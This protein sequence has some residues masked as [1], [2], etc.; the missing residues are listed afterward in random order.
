MH[1]SQLVHKFP[2]GFDLRNV[3][4][5]QQIFN[6]L[7]LLDIIPLDELVGGDRKWCVIAVSI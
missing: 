2:N 6:D 7:A 1:R 4:L 3:T 5:F